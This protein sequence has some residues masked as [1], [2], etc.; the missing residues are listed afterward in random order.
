MQNS[1]IDLTLRAP[2]FMSNTIQLRSRGV[3]TLPK[4]LRDK[5]D[6]DEG[7]VLHVVDV[8]GAFVLTPVAPVV[9]ELSR[10]IERLR[11]DAGLTTDDLLSRLQDE[12]RRVTRTHYGASPSDADE[13]SKQDG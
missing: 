8:D 13:T 4:A 12:R 7:D 6:L 1:Y 5:Y 10:K 11:K 9:P 3:V 2:G